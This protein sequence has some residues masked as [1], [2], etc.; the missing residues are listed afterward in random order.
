MIFCSIKAAIQKKLVSIYI[1]NHSFSDFI[2]I[3]TLLLFLYI[4]FPD[5]FC[6]DGCQVITI[7]GDY[8]G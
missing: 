8:L 3:F 1:V 6:P 7:K 2:T 4:L 5:Y